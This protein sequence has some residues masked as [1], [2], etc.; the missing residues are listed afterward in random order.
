MLA[1]FFPFYNIRFSFSYASALNFGAKIWCSWL[2][3]LTPNFKYTI[4]VSDK[5]IGTIK[6]IKIGNNDFSKLIKNKTGRSF[7][8]SF[9]FGVN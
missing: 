6:L 2:M 8:S 3:I 7:N 1:N 5:H 4:Y 9:G